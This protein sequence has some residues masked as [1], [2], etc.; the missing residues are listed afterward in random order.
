MTGS[1]VAA[2]PRCAA[3]IGP[4]LSGKTSL[5]E[6]LLWATGTVSRKG[7]VA[8]GNTVGDAWPEARARGMSVTLSAAD[9]D[10]LGDKWTFLDC[11]GAADFTQDTR[12]ALMVADIAVVVCEP[13]PGKV[14]PLAPLFKFLDDHRIP[15]ILFINK[16][17]MAGAQVRAVLDSL[18]SVSSRPLV[19]REVP[20]RA[21]DTIDGYVDLVSQR[22]YR[23]HDDS[24]SDLVKVPPSTADRETEARQELLETLADFDD[25]I[26][27]QLLDDVAPEQ[28]KVY[29]DLTEDL[30]KDLIVPVFF[31]SA[32]RAFGVRRLLKALRHETP[33]P[34]AAAA[35]RGIDPQAGETIAEVFKTYHLPHTGKISLARVWTG[36][37]RDGNDL[38]G[39]KASGVYRMQGA[40]PHKFGDAAGPGSVIGLGRLENAGTGDCL[41][42]SG[43]TPESRAD[44]ETP[45]QPVLATALS[46]D[47]PN[48]EVKMTSALAKLVD[49]DPSYRVEQNPDTQQIVLWGQ[50]DMHLKLALQKLKDR[51]GVDA[52][53]RDVQVPYKESIRHTATRHARFKRQTGGHG[54]F[55]D[56]MIEVAP[57][58]RG[59]G[60]SFSDAIVGGVVPRQYIP[61]VEQGMME[62]MRR[63]PLGFPVVDI[64]AKLTGGSYHSVDSSEQ[65]FKTAGRIALNEALPE[66]SPVLLEPVNKVDIRVPNAFTAKVHALISSRRGQILGLDRVEDWEGWDKVEAFIPQG[67]MQDLI[68]ELR[69]LSQ[70][71]G[72]FTWT[73]DHLQEVTGKLAD[74]IATTA[75]AD[76]VA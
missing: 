70:G 38:D 22:A 56:V 27:E 55:A 63:G 68:I 34:E 8:D 21:G 42:G 74:R 41:T 16:V 47:N 54:Q 29:A 67:E 35:R 1:G 75:G 69:S 6:S 44:W 33:G 57:Q 39:E 15:H 51:F 49:E 32:E 23:F 58:S 72:S 24:P 14:L 60:F 17:D 48:D 25:E 12:D 45:P 43:S 11:P 37:I 71:A 76:A 31:G 9:T 4:Y 50:G 61:A 62:A 2:A 64:A 59:S 73:F 19:L 5:L 28:G 20:T 3:L 18:Q 26:L 36:E 52:V 7:T 65:A 40:T 10:Y 66:C 46:V 53:T 13:D 30:Q